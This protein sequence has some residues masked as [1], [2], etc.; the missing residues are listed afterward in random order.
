MNKWALLEVSEKLHTMLICTVND[1]E[2]LHPDMVHGPYL[3][4]KEL[5]GALN[6]K[7][8]MQDL[9]EFCLP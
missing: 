7:C 4:N 2:N 6:L 1:T 8:L 5:A 3:Y 9:T